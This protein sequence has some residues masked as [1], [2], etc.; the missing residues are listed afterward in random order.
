MY[1]Q[2]FAKGGGGLKIE[3]FWRNFDDVFYFSDATKRFRIWFFLSLIT[4]YSI[5]KT[6]KSRKLRPPRRTLIA[7]QRNFK[8]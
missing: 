5:C 3:K 4:S 8:V 2:D 7:D 6:T 1:N